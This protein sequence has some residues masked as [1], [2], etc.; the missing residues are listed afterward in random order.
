[1]KPQIEKWIASC[2]REQLRFAGVT[3]YLT[4]ISDLA[5]QKWSYVFDMKNEQPICIENDTTNTEQE[6][7]T[8]ND[9][10]SE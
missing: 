9:E 7:E 2:G 8:S 3:V 5:M 4:S 1:M 6:G 10:F